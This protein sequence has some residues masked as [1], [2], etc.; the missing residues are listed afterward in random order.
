MV[1]S[2]IPKL[3]DDDKN[4]GDVFSTL[5]REIDRVFDQFP[6]SRRRPFGNL[7]AG[8]GKL[9]PRVNLSETDKE[10]E[11][12]AELPGVEEKEIDVN[13]TDD[14]LTIK[15]EKK[16][17]AEKSEGDY[18]MIERSYGSFERSMRLPC[19]VES[20]KV[21]ATFKNGVLTVKLPKSPEAKAK[22]QKIAIKA[23]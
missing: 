7:M 19:E 11:V 8:N 18:K 1:Q 23:G 9:S 5:H 20:E 3:W 21:E 17:E 13:L 12:T 4:T 14:I 6:G 22:T 16:M 15:G 2:L 10:I